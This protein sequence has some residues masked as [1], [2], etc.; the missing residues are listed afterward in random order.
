METMNHNVDKIQI[1]GGFNSS[2]NRIDISED[3]FQSFKDIM[4]LTQKDIGNISKGFTERTEANGMIILIYLQTNILKATLHWVQ[5]SQ[6]I[7]RETTLDGIDETSTFKERNDASTVRTAIQKNNYDNSDSLNKASDP[8]NHKNQ[9]D[10]IAQSQSLSNYLSTILGQNG[11]PLSY[12][13]S[14]NPDPK[15]NGEDDEYFQQLS[16][17]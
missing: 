17:N 6:R 8:R 15:Y 2:S 13:F 5:D 12:V 11:V 9:K 10:Q 7:I 16:I 14:E 3:G 4:F 1:H